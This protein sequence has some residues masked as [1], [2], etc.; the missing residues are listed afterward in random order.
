M[1]SEEKSLA[2]YVVFGTVLGLSMIVITSLLLIA[3]YSSYQ[4]DA[5]ERF[6][7]SKLNGIMIDETCLVNQNGSVYF[8]NQ[9]EL[10]ELRLAYYRGEDE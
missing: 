3:I 10:R 1:E 9:N 6:C 7:Q 4:Y 8:I 2:E 5:N